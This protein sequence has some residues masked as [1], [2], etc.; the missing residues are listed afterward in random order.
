M[1]GMR[2]FVQLFLP[3]LADLIEL[4]NCKMVD[5]PASLSLIHAVIKAA[6]GYTV[7]QM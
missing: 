5:V 6:Q 4:R 2:P 7:L 1:L 3:L